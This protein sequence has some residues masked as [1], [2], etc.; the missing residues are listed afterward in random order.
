[1]KIGMLQLNFTIGDFFKNSDKIFWGYQKA[2]EMG[3]ELVVCSE[4]CLFGYPPKDMLC[5]QSH[6]DEQNKELERLKQMI[7]D[8]GLIIGIAEKNP[9]N[10]KPLFNSAVLIQN[11]KVMWYEQKAL[12]PTYDVFDECRYF[13]PGTR[14]FNYAYGTNKSIANYNIAVFICEDIWGGSESEGH[15]PYQYDPVQRFVGTKIDTL[16]VING[17]PYY[18]GK[19]NV[20]FDLVSG[21]ARKLNCNVVYVN[22]VGGNDDLVFDGRSFAVDKHGECITAAKAFEEDVVIVDT[23]ETELKDGEYNFFMPITH[24]YEYDRGPQNL[25]M[26]NLYQALVLGTRDYVRK[27]GFKQVVIGL[28]G[29]IDSALTA[30]IAVD[31]LGKENVFGVIMPSKFSSKGSVEDAETLAKNLGIGLYKIPIKKVFSAYKKTFKNLFVRLKEDVTEENWQARIRGNILMSLSNKFGWLV[32]S[33]GNKSEISVGYCTLYGDMAGGFSPIADQ[34][35]TQVYKLAEYINKKSGNYRIPKNTIE[36]PPSA[37]LRTDQK[38]TD[39]LPPYELLDDILKRYIEK[40]EGYDLILSERSFGEI[41]EIKDVVKKVI[42]MVNRAEHK[43]KQMPLGIKTSPKAFG[44]G[45]RWPIACKN[46]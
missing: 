15:K 43:R 28:S 6:I 36:K 22:Q 13:E 25:E 34:W 21:I 38:D 24:P 10:G 5:Y 12:L 27:T 30:C 11:G 39:S 33:T 45:R 23:S 14:K 4:L 7:G 35:K 2:V 44:S 1:M 37:E 26:Q 9:D 46:L 31:A 40:E 20:R 3:A 19:G 18:L 29:G 16:F 8:V 42:D 17:S 32:L 41:S